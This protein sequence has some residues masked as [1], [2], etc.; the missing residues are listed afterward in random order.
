MDNISTRI[1]N[2]TDLYNK[3]NKNQGKSKLKRLS[4]R[5]EHNHKWHRLP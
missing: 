3:K 2:Y 5:K 4:R 1:I